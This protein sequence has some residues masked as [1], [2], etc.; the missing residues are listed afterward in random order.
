M[1][2][3]MAHAHKALFL[4]AKVF[5]NILFQ[6]IM[7]IDIWGLK[8][9]NFFDMKNLISLYVKVF[10]LVEK[11]GIFFPDI[12][13]TQ[14]SS[15]LSNNWTSS[16]LLFF[17]LSLSLTWEIQAQFLGQKS[18][19]YTSQSLVVFMKYN[20][21][22]VAP[23]KRTKTSISWVMAHKPQ[24]VGTKLTLHGSVVHQWRWGRAN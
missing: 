21:L 22:G 18:F 7:C 8:F 6:W 5:L 9:H 15:A 11:M 13:K 10:F 17:L 4:Y 14:K 2:A 20:K 24:N 16:S 1:E 23:C 12:Q 3:T 19:L